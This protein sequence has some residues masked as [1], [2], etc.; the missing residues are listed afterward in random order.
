MAVKIFL[1]I[2]PLFG[3]VDSKVLE[4]DVDD[5]D[6]DIKS[7]STNVRTLKRVSYAISL[8]RYLNRWNIHGK[9]VMQPNYL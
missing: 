4:E 5:D 2:S 8:T 1:L 6:Y 9:Q 3:I 7:I